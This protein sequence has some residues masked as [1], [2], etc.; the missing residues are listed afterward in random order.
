MFNEVTALGRLGNDPEL[1]YT[2]DGTP[3]A[4]FSLAT[5]VGYGEKKDTIWFRVAV[6]RK[7]AESANQYLAK[8]RTVLIVGPLTTREYTTNS[9]E[10]RTQLEITAREMKFVGDG[11]G[12]GGNQQ[13]YQQ[14][15]PTA[16][17]A[18]NDAEDLPW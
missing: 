17:P 14:Q 1:R 4:N 7:M 6:W 3:V 5:D 16:A 15:A 9:G 8:G 11:G 10:K 12:G 13:Q 2:P 18:S